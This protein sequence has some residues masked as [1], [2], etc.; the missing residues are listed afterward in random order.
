MNYMITGISGIHLLL[1]PL[2][3]AWFTS[4]RCIHKEADGKRTQAM[5][6]CNLPAIP[7]VRLG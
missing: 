6:E 5:Q 2:L 1:A 4:F 7:F 3:E